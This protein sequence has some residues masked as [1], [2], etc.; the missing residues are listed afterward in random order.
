[1]VFQLVILLHQLDH[2]SVGFLGRISPVQQDR[3]NVYGYHLIICEDI[4]EHPVKVSV[5]MPT[6]N[7]AVPVLKAAVDSILNQSFRDFE[8]IIVDD[9]STDGSEAYLSSLSDP[10]IRLLRNMEQLG[11]TKSLNVGLRAAKGR[12][13]A[14]MD[15]DDISLPERFEKQVAFMESHPD[16]IACGTGYE[17]IGA[18]S[19]V[20]PG[21]SED[22]NRYRAKMLFTN[23]G[24]PHPTAFL[25]REK[26]SEHHVLYDESLPYAQDYRLWA[27]ICRYGNIYTLPD[28]LL[29]RR[30]HDRQ[31]S[32][33]H[34][35][36]QIQCDKATQGKL[37]EELLGRVTGEELDLHYIHSTGYYREATISPE[38]AAWYTR[39]IRANESLGMYNQKAVKKYVVQI[40]KRLIRQTFSRD[41]SKAEKAMLFFRYLPFCSAVKATMETTLLKIRGRQTVHNNDSQSKGMSHE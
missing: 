16:A 12:Y 33:Q 37:L 24:P 25:D 3:E 27:D 40:E 30:S 18:S 39:L 13:I 6:Y 36:R 2:L 11:V 8:F 19:G 31:V 4:M 26:L 23:P 35:E 5:V 38:I 21:K 29:Q 28:V 17:N 15:S 7:T 41:M 20:H 22:M 1:M 14:R 32:R 34:R 10:R 9:H